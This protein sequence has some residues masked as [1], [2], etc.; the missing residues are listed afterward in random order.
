MV[1]FG[2]RLRGFQDDVNDDRDRTLKMDKLHDK[3]NSNNV[4]LQKF[5]IFKN[6]FY[7]Q[8]TEEDFDPLKPH[9][10][11]QGDVGSC[12]CNAVAS[13]YRY[14]LQR[15]RK[16]DFLPSRL[17]LYYVV[18]IDVKTQGH[19]ESEC[20]KYYAGLANNPPPASL[21]MVKDEGSSIRKNFR[22]LA[23]LGAPEEWPFYKEWKMGTWPYV[24]TPLDPADWVKLAEPMRTFA[25][26]SDDKTELFEK[27]A[28]PAIRPDEEAFAQAQKHTIIHYGRP[29]NIQSDH[30]ATIDC[31]KTCIANGYPVIFGL[32]EYKGL[33]NTDDTGSFKQSSTNGDFLVDTPTAKNPYDTAHT[34]LA[35]GWDDT[36]K[37]FL[38]QNSWGKETTFSA[39]D[40]EGFFYMSYDW[41]F[42]DSPGDPQNKM[43]RGAWVLVDTDEQ[44]EAP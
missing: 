43:A 10:Y 7:N 12:T 35:V 15:Q 4:K 41:L 3:K 28:L 22:V 11:D 44:L 29:H 9:V 14:A 36:K 16:P 34:V 32:D 19:P 37:A 24:E 21:F 26:P 1:R 31:W 17:F 20:G 40:W 5:S 30:D 18:R 39:D 38:V 27:T 8:A 23:N 42:I 25:Q 6:K 13:A 33:S 2:T